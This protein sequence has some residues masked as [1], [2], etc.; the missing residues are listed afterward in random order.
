MVSL[1]SWTNLPISHPN[2]F[3]SSHLSLPLPLSSPDE[4]GTCN[5]NNDSPTGSLLFTSHDELFLFCCC[6]SSS[7]CA[8]KTLA[9]RMGESASVPPWVDNSGKS[10]YHDQLALVH[11]WIAHAARKWHSPKVSGTSTDGGKGIGSEKSSLPFRRVSTSLF[12]FCPVLS[13][14]LPPLAR[15]T[16]SAHNDRL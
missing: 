11:D 2:F 6:S 15:T 4:A 7:S 14:S 12:L 8:Q 13:L 10:I 5:R 16:H 3:S 9:L 1:A